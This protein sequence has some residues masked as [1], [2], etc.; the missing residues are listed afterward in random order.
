MGSQR[1]GKDCPRRGHA[2]GKSSL[3]CSQQA[4]E[5]EKKE[6]WPIAG[7]HA[8]AAPQHQAKAVRNRPVNG[9][10][11]PSCFGKFGLVEG[12]RGQM[13]E[14]GSLS[15]GGCHSHRLSPAPVGHI[16]GL[17][18]R[19]RTRGKFQGR[20]LSNIPGARMEHPWVPGNMVFCFCFWVDPWELDIRKCFLIGCL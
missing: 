11:Q 7:S 12:W 4:V 6:G 14:Q 9:H 18:G 10:L 16:L 19:L 1:T 20:T 5:R 13:T 2:G 17:S 3:V 15:G 8:V